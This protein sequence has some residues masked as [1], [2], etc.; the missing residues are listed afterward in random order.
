[1]SFYVCATILTELLMVAMVL[2][3]TTYNG[4]NREQKIWFLLTFISIMICAGAEF[5]VHCGYYNP[6]HSLLLT[7]ITVF[8]FSLAP[9][10][11]V[12]FSGALGLYREA[13]MAILL[14]PISFFVEIVCA[15]GGLIFFFDAEGYHRGHLFL[16]YEL[17][18]SVSIL[19]LIISLFKVGM[20]FYH[21]DFITIIMI[22]VILAAGVVPM[23]FFKINIT[24]SAIGLI[25]SLCYIYY[26]D[27]V[28]QD[29]KDELVLQQ[30]KVTDIQEHTISGLANL[31]ESRD[32]ETGE[33]VARTS[34][35]VKTLAELARDDGVYEDIID[36]HFIALIY[37]LA[38]LHDVGKIVVS[39]AILKKPGR[40]TAEE[41]EE[42]KQHA[43]SGG[44]VVRQIL[45]GVTDEEYIKIAADIA[46]YHHE[47]WNGE[48]YPEG[49][50]GEDIPLSAR[51]MAIAD[52]FDALISERCYKKPMPVEQAFQIIRTDAGSHFDPKLAGVFL[53]H[54]EEFV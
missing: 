13:K 25:A 31:I 5:T 45:S 49:R 11:A 33:H 28:Q 17:F 29:T 16:I 30:Q 10:L 54:K 4:F 40:L 39:D 36:D 26:N 21:R 8:Q 46:T 53:N 48:G 32:M 43:S 7:V 24:Y 19:Y 1:M 12:F 41:Y 15:P 47:K 42:M 20:N 6:D 27:L 2:H 38:P 50:K 52:V 51:I 23:T 9:I 35:Y 14:L 3:V 22:I 37:T 34:E 18:Y 44:R